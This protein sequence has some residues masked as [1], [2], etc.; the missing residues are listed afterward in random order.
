MKRQARQTALAGLVVATAL[1]VGCGG[2]KA[3]YV[4]PNADLGAIKK[5]AV[6]P[7]ENLSQDP[8]AGERVQSLFLVEL[9]SKNAFDVIEPG[10]VT[11]VLQGARIQSTVAMGP[12]DFK[13]LGEE[14]QVDGFFLGTVVD[15][16][17]SQ[18]G[19][20][21]PQVTIQLRLVEAASGATVW[22]ASDSSSGSSFWRRLFG[23]G[24]KSLSEV[25]SDLVRRELDSLVD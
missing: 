20:S 22:S 8:S 9:L 11:K 1:L 4:H 15:F 6:L 25:S 12:S 23:V 2:S 16:G 18:S 24:G 19:S 10:Q 5:A 21:A 7:F 14:L 13:A 17:N 3:R